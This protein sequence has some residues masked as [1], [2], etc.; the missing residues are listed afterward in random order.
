MEKTE[1][2]VYVDRILMNECPL[3]GYREINHSI[4]AKCPWR[5]DW[6]YGGL[7][8]TNKID[9]GYYDVITKIYKIGHYNCLMQKSLD[10]G[11]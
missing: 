5:E 6:S 4:C 1:P 9:K 7:V 11:K 2:N 3:L 10:N 8:E